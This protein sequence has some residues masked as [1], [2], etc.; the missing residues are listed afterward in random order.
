MRLVVLVLLGWL[1]VACASASVADNRLTSVPADAKVSLTGVHVNTPEAVKS[2]D[3]W[4]AA[5]RRGFEDEA[6][7]LGIDGGSLAVDVVVTTCNPGSKSARYWVGFGAGKGKL[8]LTATLS[9]HGEVVVN[10]SVTMGWTGGSFEDVCEEAGAAAA[11]AIG[12]AR[13]K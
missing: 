13:G 12:E 1:S 4:V 8:E 3:E 11:R 7:E 2:E 6:A 9:G 5:I 10:G